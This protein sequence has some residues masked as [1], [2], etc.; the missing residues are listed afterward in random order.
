MAIT[1]NLCD[2]FKL[3]SIE[4]WK[5]IEYA[6]LKSGIKV[7]E[8]TITQNLL[9]EINALS[10]QFDL[11]INIFEAVDENRNGN[12]LELIIR[13]PKEGTEFYTPIQGK[14]VY[15][16]QTYGSIDHGNQIE[17]LL[18]YALEKRSTAFYLFYNYTPSGINGWVS[19]CDLSLF[20]CSMVNANFIRDNYYN[21]KTKRNG[22]KGWIIPTLQKLIPKSFPWHE[23]VCPSNPIQLSDTL[24]NKLGFPN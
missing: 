16:N 17:T 15:R 24:S 22:S 2:L 5:R 11:D 7:F 20:G 10:D 21:K 18:N 12:D 6:Y 3:L 8:T 9:F 19:P 23:L 13:Y 4:T 1:P 14:K